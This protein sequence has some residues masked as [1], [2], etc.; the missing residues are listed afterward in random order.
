MRVTHMLT[1]GGHGLPEQ[2]E[3]DLAGELGEEDLP[4][5]VLISLVVIA[6]VPTSL[7]LE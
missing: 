6:M 7:S 3:A 2:P 5:C 1:W 4:E